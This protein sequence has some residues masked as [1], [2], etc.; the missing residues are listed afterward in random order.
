MATSWI[1]ATAAAAGAESHGH[2]VDWVLVASLFAN[3]IVFFGVLFYFAAPLVSRSLKNRRSTMAAE[4]NR[5]QEKRAEAEAKLAEYQKKLDDLEQEVAKVV[6]AYEREAHAD[7][8]RIERDTEKEITRLGREADFSIGQ[9]V[10]E[11]E[12]RIRAEAVRLT[13]EA[14]EARVRSQIGGAD[15]RRLTERYIDGLNDGLS[16]RSS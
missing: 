6:Q 7:R 5:A 12:Q 11:A 9:A 10:K 16:G 15:H 1:L 3:V 13:I 8:A 4:L 14:A 2:G